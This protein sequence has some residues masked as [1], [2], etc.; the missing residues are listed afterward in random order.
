[1]VSLVVAIY[2]ILRIKTSVMRWRLIKRAYKG[3]Y[4]MLMSICIW[5]N[6]VCF[7]INLGLAVS[8]YKW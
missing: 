2:P 1:V 4:G 6:T 5:M 8:L 7:M 3:E